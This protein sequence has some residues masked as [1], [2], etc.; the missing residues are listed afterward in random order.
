[1]ALLVSVHLNDLDPAKAVPVVLGQVCGTLDTF[2]TVDADPDRVDGESI[3]F[4]RG[5]W[6]KRALHL[7][8]DQYP[9]GDA[10]EYLHELGVRPVMY[11]TDSL[12]E[13]PVAERPS[14]DLD[15]AEGEDIQWH[16]IEVRIKEDIS[17]LAILSFFFTN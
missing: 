8:F 5:G 13:L 3:P 11:L 10:A 1:V 6:T 16:I 2:S 17:G 15:D 12:E 7:H 4:R 9:T 14:L